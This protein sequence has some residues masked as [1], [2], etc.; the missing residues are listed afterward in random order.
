MRLFAAHNCINLYA[1]EV[2]ISI[3]A[4][5]VCCKVLKSCSCLNALRQIRLQTTVKDVKFS[6]KRWIKKIQSCLLTLCT[7]LITLLC[8]HGYIS[9]SNHWWNHYKVTRWLKPTLFLPWRSWHKCSPSALW[10]LRV[11]FHRTDT[12]SLIDPLPTVPTECSIWQTSSS[13]TRNLVD[14]LPIYIDYHVVTSLLILCYQP[15]VADSRATLLIV[16]HEEGFNC[17]LT[18]SQFLVEPSVSGPSVLCFTPDPCCS[19]SNLFWQL[20]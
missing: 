13:M 14:Y 7:S 9:G 4:W 15:A 12:I 6:I 5:A 2:S 18:K 16:A 8:N 10:V 11:A 1:S 3:P 20:M 17:T 19:G